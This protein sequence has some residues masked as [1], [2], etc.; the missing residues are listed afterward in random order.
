MKQ[1]VWVYTISRLLNQ[2]E[3]LDLATKC[4]AFVSTWT[5]H[6][7]SLDATFEIYKNRLLIIKVNEEKYNA[8][9][10]SID[11]QL[12]FIKELEN[13]FQVEMLNRLLVAFQNNNEVDVVKS[14]E[15]RKL[16]DSGKI[17]EETIVYNNTITDSIQLSEHWKIPLKNSWLNKYLKIA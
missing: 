1:R 5:A 17:D 10:C 15:I 3:L 6:D 16:L 11:K 7:I 4:R 2:E 13:Q 9:G 12:R 8:S 14:T